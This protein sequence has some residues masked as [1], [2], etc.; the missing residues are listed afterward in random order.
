[1]LKFFSKTTKF[2]NFF[3]Q[4]K[5]IFCFIL[6]LGIFVRIYNFPNIPPNL[7][8]DEAAA[9]YEAFSLLKTGMD[10]WGEPFPVYFVAWGSG[11][12]VLYSYLSIPFIHFFGLNSGSTRAINLLTGILNIVILYF[13]IKDKESNKK[14]LLASLFLAISPWGIMSS[15]WG[16]ESNLLPFCILLGIF[17]LNQ[18][19]K[20]KYKFLIPISLIPLS[21]SV[22]AYTLA[23]PVASLIVII[24]SIFYFKQISRNKILWFL[25]YLL[26]F[27]F[28]SP[29]LIFVIQ[30]NIINQKLD[31]LANFPISIPLLPTNRFSQ[32]SQDG[33]AYMIA[34]NIYFFVAG[35][36]DFLSWNTNQTFL[37]LSFVIFPFSLVGLIEL[38]KRYKRDKVLNWF[39]LWFLASLSLFL[40][41]PLNQNRGNSFFIPMIV[42]ATFGFF[43]VLEEFKTETFKNFF[44]IVFL[45]W[46]LAYSLIFNFDYQLVYSKRVTYDFQYEIDVAMQKAEEITPKNQ[47]IYL[48]TEVSIN[49]I[50]PLFYKKIDPV[51]FRQNANYEIINGV[52]KVKNWRNYYYFEEEMNLRPVEKFSFIQKQTEKNL[53]QKPDFRWESKIWKVG[54]CQKD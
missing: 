2:F 31:F 16:L 30:N 29:F 27:L 51:D 4:E 3:A 13:L 44:G 22:Y 37:P 38:I 1:M 46:F 32:T 12:N 35:M 25:A 20:P 49:Y 43:K 11:Q 45:G 7:N 10:K 19:L 24:F 54:I 39:L 18:A 23:L 17:C 6:A 28:I 47:K 53:C 21:L 48:T 26:A 41:V 14:A 8:H 52:Y 5:S 50:Y 40:I 34:S 9:G 15:R 33:F 42:F 36:P